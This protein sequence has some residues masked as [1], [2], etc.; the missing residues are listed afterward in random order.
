VFGAIAELLDNAVDAGAKTLSISELCDSESN[1]PYALVFQDDGK[2]M[3]L[4]E[5]H[6]MMS[7]GHCDKGESDIGK[8][9]NGFKSG[10]SLR[11][12]HRS[13]QPSRNMVVNVD[14]TTAQSTMQVRCVSAMMYWCSH[15]VP[16]PNP[17][18]F[19]HSRFSTISKAMYDPSTSTPPSHHRHHQY[20]SLCNH[21]VSLFHLQVGIEPA[22]DYSETN[23]LSKRPKPIREPWKPVCKSSFNGHGALR[24]P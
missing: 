3:S 19:Y 18:G 2:G 23:P 6:R 5:L 22:A 9:G 4:G 7:F 12:R 16:P 11:T 21:S 17:S 24:H 13:V 1:E 15:R 20:Q 14:N 10:M 8:Y